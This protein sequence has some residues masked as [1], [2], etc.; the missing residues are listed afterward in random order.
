[1]SL[2]A[3]NLDDRRFQDLVDDAKRL[4]A[5]RCRKWTDH[6]VSDPGV[7]LIETFAFMTDELFY[8]LN[9]V[10]DKLYV[11]FLDLIGITLYPPTAATADVV[12]WLA[13]PRTDVVVVPAR[14]EVATP[15]NEQAESIVFQ[16][17]G[18]LRIPPRSLAHVGSRSGE[19]AT[20]RGAR[21]GSDPL[22]AFSTP[23]KTGDELLIGLDQPAP[24]LAIGIRL[25]CTVRGVGVDPSDPPTVW[26]SWNGSGWTPCDL[27]S[28]RTG[29][30]NQAGEVRLIVAR[31]HVASVIG[32]ENA[33]W[34][35]CR[36]VEREEGVPTYKQPPLV[37]EASADTVG[38]V[39]VAMHARTVDEE[40]LGLSEGVPGQSFALQERPVVDDGEAFVVEVGSGSGWQEWTEVDS[41]A[42]SGEDDRHVVVDRAN[43][44]VAFPPAVREPDGSLRR[45]GAVPPK[46]APL[47]VPRYRVGGG[48]DGNVSAA[49]LSV[50]RSTVPFVKGAVNRKAAHDGTDG[51]T[52][53]EAKVRGPLALRTRDRAVTLGD[54]EQL[55]K[56]AAPGVG[57]TRA[58]PVD[59]GG[60]AGVRLLV[61]P[62]V[63][64]DPGGRIEYA[65]LQPGPE[66]L[67]AISDELETRR[68]AGTRLVIEPPEYRGVTVVARLVAGPR[69]A[70]KRL[71]DEAL[72]TL[73][74]HFDPIH[75]GND[76][77][78]WP[79]GRPVLAGEVYAVLQGLPGTELVDDVLLFEADPATGERGEPV[80][81]IGL[82]PSALVYSFA[83]SVRVTSGV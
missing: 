70:V 76:G 34:I 12:M 27:V 78:G 81:R 56:R 31:D 39:A 6:N 72:A 73:Y 30:L 26:E 41:F 18:E 45:Y 14:T 28:D 4:A 3:P 59:D 33:G 77:T 67:E 32:D 38:G 82:A 68:I 1:M 53:E 48:L 58:L 63:A 5:L 24:G 50:L 47:R 8:R 54:F 43:G 19:H 55:A 35:R 46:G 80:Q 21:L 61:V 42:G 57:R 52:V 60:G 83:H 23:P 16:T 36:I 15:R 49:S 10:P 74:R 66:L 40:I 79:F 7:T 62:T 44:T 51:E 13:A 2:P 25:D 65:D 71:Q 11:A 69:V 37:R 17:T 29:G 9:R 75:G 22:E 20:V 64:V